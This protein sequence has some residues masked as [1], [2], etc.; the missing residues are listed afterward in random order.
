MQ[1]L[2]LLQKNGMVNRNI[3]AS[4]KKIKDTNQ[5]QDTDLQKKKKKTGHLGTEAT[6]LH[7]HQHHIIYPCSCHFLLCWG[8]FA[9]FFLVRCLVPWSL[10]AQRLVW[11]STKR[12][13]KMIG[14]CQAGKNVRNT[15]QYIRTIIYNVV[16][17]Y[18]YIYID[19]SRSII[20]RHMFLICITKK[21]AG[22]AEN[23]S[24][25]YHEIKA[26]FE[27]GVCL[28]DRLQLY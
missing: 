21:T 20:Y 6:D 14:S 1:R 3:F 17:T 26:I 5:H 13:R 27:D 25:L 7:L 11:F 18:I 19:R 15:I 2:H 10:V 28:P 23:C 24:H 16:L 12:L 8:A 4:L 9:T 22:M